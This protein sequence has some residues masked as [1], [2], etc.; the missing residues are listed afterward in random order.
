MVQVSRRKAARF[1]LGKT[2]LAFAAG[3]ASLLGGKAVVAQEAAKPRTGGDLVIATQAYPGCLDPRQLGVGGLALTEITTDRLVDVDPRTGETIPYLAS[4]WDVEDGARRI[5]FHLRDGVT[6]SDGTPLT[7]AVVKQNIDTLFAAPSATANSRQ[8][9][10]G[11]VSVEAPDDKTVVF[12]FTNPRSDFLRAAGHSD[13]SIYAPAW[14]A[15]DEP[16][17]CNTIIGS[18]PFILESLSRESGWKFVR[19]KDYGWPS[20]RSG[21]EPGPFL[22]SLQYRLIPEVGVRLNGLIAGQFQVI[23]HLNPD[24]EPLLLA[25]KA[26][27][28]GAESYGTVWTLTANINKPPL[29]E[30]AVRLAA[31]YAVNLNELKQ[32]ALFGSWQRIAKGVL[33]ENTPG[34]VDFSQRLVHD[35]DRARKLLDEAGWVPGPDGIR[36]RDGKRLEVDYPYAREE[37]V[38]LLLQQQLHAVGIGVKLRKVAQSERVAI[39]TAGDYSYYFHARNHLLERSA[40]N[41]AFSSHYA[42]YIGGGRPGLSAD[43]LVEVDRLAAALTAAPTDEA[44]LAISRDFQ[45]LLL[46]EGYVIPLYPYS[47]GYAA[48]AKLHGWQFGGSGQELYLRDAWL[49][50]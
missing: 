37:Q 40:L 9:L 35:P 36:V 15:S 27:V 39:T 33:T 10:T 25:Q 49:A 30:K 23:T 8:I 41:Q 50:N 18:G 45:S 47:E 20:V 48:V 1:P 21:V 11:L 17:R 26:Q 46:D 22:D 31:L 34:F 5:V 6:F 44:A 16:T 24:H 43:K 14:L 19:R 4:S 13:V 42:N 7:A 12:T 2:V 3:A 28:F 32:G 38:V 29:D